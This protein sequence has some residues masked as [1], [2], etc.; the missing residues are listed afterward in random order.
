MTHFKR[1]QFKDEDH[2]KTETIG[3]IRRISRLRMGTDG[4]GITTLVIFFESNDFCNFCFNKFCHESHRYSA[5]HIEPVP[6]GAYTPKELLAILDKDDVYFRMSGGGVMFSGCEPLLQSAFIHELCKLTPS[7]WKMRIETSLKAPWKYVK[8]V[9]KDID[10]WIINLENIDAF[11]YDWRLGTSDTSLKDNFIKLVKRV[12]P[13]KLRVRIPIFH[14]ET[15]RWV[16]S[17]S[18]VDPE[19]FNYSH[20]NTPIK[21]Q[22]DEYKDENDEEE[23][24]EEE[25]D[26]EE[27]DEKENDEKENDEKDQGQFFDVERDWN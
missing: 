13:S 7:E 16:K 14:M 4:A 19:I 2:K 23:N 5:F 1:I 26:E 6:R 8:P 10:E 25:N 17:V 11:V 12:D 9:I 24:D 21:Y 27:N 3:D 15:V 18:G 22:L 20:Y